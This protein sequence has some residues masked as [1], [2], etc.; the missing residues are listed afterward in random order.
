MSCSFFFKQLFPVLFFGIWFGLSA[1]AQQQKA[2]PD[3]QGTISDYRRMDE[4]RRTLQGGLVRD[5]V[6]VHWL[7]GNRLWYRVNAGNN[8]FEWALVD[9]DSNSKEPLFDENRIGRAIANAQAQANGKNQQPFSANRIRRISLSDDSK[10]MFFQLGKNYWR[11][12]RSSYKL[13]KIE[14]SQLPRSDSESLSEVQPSRDDGGDVYLEIENQHKQSVRLFWID[15]RGKKRSYGVLKPG[16]TERQHTFVGHVWLVENMSGSP[17]K[18][19]RA[20]Q[21]ETVV[22]DQSS[23][24]VASAAGDDT[25][26]FMELQ[27][28]LRNLTSPDRRWR[29]IVQNH[30]LFL[31]N[32]K[33]DELRQVT[34]DGAAENAYMRRVYW[35]PDSSKLIVVRSKP[36]AKHLVHMVESSPKT[37]LQPKLHSHQYLKPGDDVRQDRPCLIDVITGKQ[38]KVSN[39]LFDNPYAL[40]DFSWT[41][42]SREFRFVYNQRGH[43]VLRYVGID[44]ATGNVR[45]IIGETSNT[46]VNYSGK[47]FLKTIP[48]TDELVW[49]SERD[50][51][52]HLYLID[53]KN[54]KVKN[55]ITKGDWVVR[56]VKNLDLENRRVYFTASGWHAEQDPY[57]VHFGHAGL[58]GGST[59]KMTDDNGSHS[60][61]YSPNKKVFVDTFSRVDLPPVRQLRETKTGKLLAELESADASALVQKGWQAPKPFRA[62][63]RD[64]KTDIYGVVYLPANMDPDKKYPVVEYIYAGPHDSFVPKKFFRYRPEKAM[65]ELGFVV[66]QIDG[67]GT[68]NRSKAFHDVCW[69]NLGDSGFP[70]RI[71]WMKA[72]AKQYPQMDLTRVGIF[73]GSAGG[74]SALRALLAHGDFY[75]A[76]VAD[77][78]CH[79]NRMDKIWWNEQWMGWPIGKHYAAQSNVTNAHKLKGKLLLI[80]GELDRNVDPASTMQVVSALIKADRDFELLVVPGAGHGV[81]SGKYGTRRTRDFFVRSLLGVEP[82]GE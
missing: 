38:V 26:S 4:L 32:Q 41:Q 20:A 15:R 75:D 77:C 6:Q 10:T 11:L 7:S 54:G 14:R 36:E 8:R 9:Y 40:R 67:M 78:G 65:A 13:D 30:N 29:A 49:M 64:G 35:S 31:K 21:D 81:G 63:G 66:V 18:I 47:Y 50:G 42:D 80:V 59:T 33:T 45:S 82:R 27:K 52:N 53:A 2:L 79:D 25:D 70:D 22:V 69:K 76:A 28:K 72:A 19:F 60:V 62:K 23:A 12:D 17:I 1:S 68:S 57:F 34:N 71:A 61:E 51:W 3:H 44:A 46:F 16:Q 48:K 37:Q 43:Q 39:E 58:D 74:Q 5:Q 55:Q 24:V 73:G 56:R